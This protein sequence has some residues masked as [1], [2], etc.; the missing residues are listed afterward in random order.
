MIKNEVVYLNKRQFRWSS[1]EAS[2]LGFNFCTDK[3]HIFQANLEPKI[4]LFEKCLK[5]WQHR[6]L[7]LMS[8]ITVVK[9]YALP[10]LI[11]ALSSLPNPPIET[12]KRI[13]KRMYEFIWDGKPEKIKRDILTMG[14]ENGGLKMI[15][16]D[17]FIK[18]LKV[19]WI[20]RMIE[21]DYDSILN[22]KL[23]YTTSLQ[24]TKDIKLQ[25]FNYKFL[26][27]IIPTNRYLLKCNTCIG[28][29]TL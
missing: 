22:W 2:A 3:S 7:T 6:K 26:M 10:K 23:I 28:H 12:V 4:V 18:A 8:K 29:T 1:K 9:S 19:S 20:K 27:R 13:E 11:Y 5:Q 24:A 15:D 25:N 17:N 16:I 14:Y 21:A